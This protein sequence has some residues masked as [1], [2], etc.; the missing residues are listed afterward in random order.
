VKDI[1]Y[2]RRQAAAL[3]LAACRLLPKALAEGAGAPVR[4]A[5][6]ENVVGDVNLNDA[7]V[8]MQVWLK[9]LTANLNVTLDPKLFNT[10]QEIVE[11]TRRGLLDAVAV[12]VLEYRQIASLLD[13]S[14][15][16]NSAGEAGMEQYL[17]LA[18]KSSAVRRL[19]DLKGRRLS[20]LKT[21]KT[22]LAPAW[23]STILDE[24]S[25]GPA[26]QFFGLVTTAPKCSRVVLPVFFGQAD[27]CLT[28]KRGF[29]TMCELNPQVGKDLATLVSSP[30]VTVDFYIFRKNYQSAEREA[31]IRAI[32]GLRNSPGGQELA[33]LFQFEQLTV[34]DGNC[35]T[36]A[37]NL[38]DMADR[39]RARQA[40]GSK[41]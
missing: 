24:G 28:S 10:T 3:I 17:I 15:I 12:N 25:H 33:T 41:K 38:L 18:K 35:L 11:R 23:L 1:E 16:V 37:L 2:S 27:C 29:E 5:I 7:R 19:G 4:L 6:S 34:R 39:A 40:A 31:V 32:S 20:M 30:S 21:P 22:C 36:S 14:Q 13:S 8:A 9:R 26:E